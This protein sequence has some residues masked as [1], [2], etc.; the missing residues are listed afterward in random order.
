MKFTI[1]K[2]IGFLLLMM[3]VIA[4][5]NLL[6]VYQFIE[7]QKF[8]FHIINLAGRQR[9]LAQRLARFSTYI[10][11]GNESNRERIIGIIDTYDF[12]LNCMQNG[13]EIEGVIIPK[14]P[15]SMDKIFNN[16]W[17]IWLP[18]KKSVE[19]VLKEIQ[20]NNIQFN[21]AMV[22]IIDNNEGFLKNN[23]TILNAYTKLN[24]SDKEIQI[25]KNLI[26]YSQMIVK[27]AFSSAMRNYEA[28][29]NLRKYIDLYD[30]SLNTLRN[31]TTLPS[32]L[33]YVLVDNDKIWLEFK[34]KSEILI[35]K[36]E[37]E[38]KALNNAINNVNLKI[39]T[40]IDISNETTN[41]F[42]NIFTSKMTLL[43]R[44]LLGM[45][46]LDVLMIIIGW[47][48][49]EIHIIKPLKY[50]AN[51]AEKIGKGGFQEDL[52][53]PKSHDEIEELARSFNTM[54]NDLKKTTVSKIYVDN[55]ISSM[56][57]S[58][59]I[60]NLDGTIR[61]I[62]QATT[63]ILGYKEEE[64]VGL[65]FGT[66]LQHESK[67]FWM[68]NLLD[69]VKQNQE[70]V[71]LTKDR[72]EIPVAFSNSIMLDVDGNTNGIVC[73][74]QDI[75]D[76]KKA[77]ETIKNDLKAAS[78]MQRKL[79]PEPS[80]IKGFR[81]NWIFRPSSYLGGDM[82]NYFNLD[83]DHI[84]FYL[85]DVTGHGLPAALLSFNLSKT[86][87]PFPLEISPLKKTIPEPPYHEVLP[88]SLAVEEINN[89]FQRQ[90]GTMQYFTMIYALINHQTNN[91]KLLR[92]G[93]AMPIFLPKNGKAIVINKGGLPV[94][95]LPNIK[96]DGEV[97]LAFQ[98][99]DRLFIYSDG[100]TDCVNLENE[101]FSETRLIEF[102]ENNKELPLDKF[103]HDLEQTLLKWRG[104]AEFVDDISMLSIEKLTY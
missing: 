40:L 76:L 18:I 86:L 16:N 50:L 82:F 53:V 45:L 44:I 47:K 23:I 52:L 42:V 9:M 61:Q 27:Y 100:I 7:S 73:V 36:E 101:L 26:K 65:P 57:N 35:N 97:E 37:I 11:N 21:D 33:N 67:T 41:V 10:E 79:L 48:L 43:K 70:K 55:I 39:N 31:D 104:D 77:T 102:I 58:L 94:G 72:K 30:Q 56:I 8:N 22:Y 6:I 29:D 96:Y 87:S 68:N 88:P 49:S 59:I 66:I 12:S 51:T 93:H 81:F 20:N 85:L 5:I 60:I 92:A 80:I 84:G 98:R 69:D 32:K 34:K 54:L 17:K 64:L 3:T 62:N 75:T 89:R 46:I 15:K 99:G 103:M 91:L 95:M 38:N 24:N 28:K 25:S 63:N 14:A 78:S 4:V 90:K 83:E 13:G 1:G 74:A 19:D 2:K 71:Y